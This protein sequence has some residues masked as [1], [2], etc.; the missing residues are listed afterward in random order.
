M[1]YTPPYDSRNAIS[2]WLYPIHCPNYTVCGPNYLNLPANSPYQT[3]T[4]AGKDLPALA[5]SHRQ[6]DIGRGSASPGGRSAA[7]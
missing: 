6:E 5:R 1:Y 2:S 3:R 4:A 7:T